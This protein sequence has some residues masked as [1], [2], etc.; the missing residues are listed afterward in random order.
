ML[1]VRV[2]EASRHFLSLCDASVNSAL[3]ICLNRVR[4]RRCVR[5]IKEKKAKRHTHT[6]KENRG[7]TKKKIST[8]ARAQP[9]AKKKKHNSNNYHTSR[10]QQHDINLEIK[11]NKNKGKQVGAYIAHRS[12]RP[13]C[14]RNRE[15]LF[16]WMHIFASIQPSTYGNKNS[17]WLHRKKKKDNNDNRR[18]KEKKK[19]MSAADCTFYVKKKTA[20]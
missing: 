7:R 16:L 11:Q 4:Q 17:K 15:S 20:S 10:R 3:F 8:S 1:I 18:R 13:A 14:E 12:A 9:H 6:K 5:Y 2:T 19:N